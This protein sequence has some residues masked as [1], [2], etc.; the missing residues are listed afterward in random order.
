MKNKR[1]LE[2]REGDVLIIVAPEAEHHIEIITTAIESCYRSDVF[3]KTLW[4]YRYVA[5][6]N[7]LTGITANKYD[8]DTGEVLS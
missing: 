4:N 1:T 2:N 3:D 8:L 6:L 7:E 5:M